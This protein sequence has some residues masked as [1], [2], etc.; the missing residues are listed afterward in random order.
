MPKSVVRDFTG[1]TGWFWT[2]MLTENIYKE[3][4]RLL[5]KRIVL[6]NEDKFTKNSQAFQDFYHDA[7]QFYWGTVKSWYSKNTISIC[8]FG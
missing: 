3:E 6:T 4:F 1:K 7:G 2:K 5:N 8:R